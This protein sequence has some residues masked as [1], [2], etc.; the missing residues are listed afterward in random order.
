[1]VDSLKCMQEIECIFYVPDIVICNLGTEREPDGEPMKPI[2]IPS[3]WTST[4]MKKAAIKLSFVSP[5]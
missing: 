2:G 1:M 4:V 3:N 5:S